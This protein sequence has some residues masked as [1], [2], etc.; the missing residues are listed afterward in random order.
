MTIIQS[1]ILKGQGFLYFYT[2]VPM[3][4]SYFDLYGKTLNRKIDCYVS[5]VRGFVIYRKTM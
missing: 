5:R 4:Q 3:Y 1:H 2:Y